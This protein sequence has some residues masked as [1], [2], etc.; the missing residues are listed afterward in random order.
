MQKNSERQRGKQNSQLEKSK[1]FQAFLP[2]SDI[3]LT[4]GNMRQTV[5]SAHSIYIIQDF[6]RIVNKYT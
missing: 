6:L 3:G 2:I 5:L 1:I 4:G